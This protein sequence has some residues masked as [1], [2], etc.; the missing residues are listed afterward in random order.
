MRKL[1][2][3]LAMATVVLAMGGEPAGPETPVGGFKSQS[4][5]AAV[6]EALGIWAFRPYAVALLWGMTCGPWGLR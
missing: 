5:M 4:C 3:A 6:Y 1:R 2:A